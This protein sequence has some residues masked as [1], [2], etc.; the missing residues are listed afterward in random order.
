[1]VYFQ[2]QDIGYGQV[3]G[4]LALATFFVANIQDLIAKEGALECEAGAL[5]TELTAHL[6]VYST[7]TLGLKLS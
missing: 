4:A 5:S 7:L 6:Q 1:M 3:R 2:I